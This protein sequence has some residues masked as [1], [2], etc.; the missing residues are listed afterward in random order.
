MGLST[1]DEQHPVVGGISIHS[2]TGTVFIGMWAGGSAPFRIDSLFASSSDTADN[3]AEIMIT[4]GETGNLVLGQVALPALAGSPGI[5]MVDVLLALGFTPGSL[6][7][8]IGANIQIRVLFAVTDPLEARF[9]AF[10]G[11]L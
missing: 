9:L 6:L 2:D 4:S 1:F 3:V 5:P 10:G 7:L 8:G 11:T